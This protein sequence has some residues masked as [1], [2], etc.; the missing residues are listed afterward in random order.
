VQA[1][2]LGL[3][4]VVGVLGLAITVWVFLPA[5]RGPEAARRDVGT[6][7]LVFGVF[8]AFLAINAAIVLILTPILHFERGLTAVSLIVAA[9]ATDLTMFG[10]IFFRLVLPGAVTWP[11]LGLRPLSVDY[12]L[13]TGL[14]A[15]FAGL[16]VTFAVELVLSQVGLRPNQSQ[17][18]QSVMA[19]G[20]L[21][22]AAL[23]IAAGVMA[24]IVEEL[25]FRGFIFGLYRRRK[26]LWQAYLISAVLFTL[27]H[28]DPTRMD[29]AQ[30]AALSIGIVI[31]AVMLAW[32]YQYTGSLYP[33][34]V[35]HA[36]N[37]S[38]N[39][40]LLYVADK[41]PR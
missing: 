38:A 15:G 34:I 13:L 32:L 25:F 11:D 29:A 26:P 6:H 21:A 20:P 40:I 28:N 35:A 4:A 41:L 37:N 3:L 31:L 8:F 30:M 39:L 5:F 12:V 36:V 1:L 24:P 19:E 23:L 9:V 7:R 2:G 14:G 16:A 10:F 33:S 18:F 22:F 17:Q 27:L